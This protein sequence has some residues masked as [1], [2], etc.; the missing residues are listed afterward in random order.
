M[1]ENLIQIINTFFVL[2]ILYYGFANTIYFVLLIL[3]FKDLRKNQLQNFLLMK[4]LKHTPPAYAPSISI[5][6]P[7]YNEELTIVGSVKSFL[8]LN[9]P[10]FE[11][12]VVNDGS[13]DGTLKQL[14]EHFKLY[15]EVIFEDDRL[16][17]APIN[18][19]YRSLSHPNLVV[20][21]KQNGGKAD[22]INAGLAVSKYPLFCAVDSDSILESDALLRI[23]LPFFEDPDTTVASGGTIRLVNGS[24]L[25]H[26]QVIRP[27]LSRQPLILL[28]NVEYIRAFLCGRVGWNALNATLV[29]SGAF[30]LFNKEAVLG[31]GSYNKHSI[32]EDM[33]LVVR[34][35]RYCKEVAK[36]PYRII[37]IP[38]P[39][40][41]T[42]APFELGS[43]SRQRV[44]WQRGLADTLYKYK[45]LMRPRYGFM[46]LLALPYFFLVEL[47]GPLIEIIS[48]IFLGLAWYFG[49]LNKELLLLFFL[50]GLLYGVFM[51]LMA[52]LLEEIY[53]RKVSSVKEF[54]WLLLFGILEAFGFRQLTSYWRIKG[55]WQHFRGQRAE[56]GEMKRKGL[57]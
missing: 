6:A 52:I 16:I 41:W 18:K 55:L 38:D 43:L 21:D 11:V 33:E 1:K 28:Q 24:K 17:H 34:L 4:E 13:K 5:I 14:I 7:A 48:W 2:S 27:K 15:E 36:R 12:V 42:E 23:A 20:V 45:G 51:T 30:G 50:I 44:R 37:F 46:G 22:A 47:W 29:I 32:G 25:S 56:W 10:L 19:T 40:C 31:A 3:A 26:G 39:V 49:I 57:S 9:Y 53:F 35:H 8:V 54:L